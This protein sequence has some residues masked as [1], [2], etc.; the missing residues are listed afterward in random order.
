MA[1]FFEVVYAEIASLLDPIREASLSDSGLQSLLGQLG[2]DLE[3][4]QGL[5]L[6]PLLTALADVAA[7]VEAVQGATA[8]QVLSEV[9]AALHGVTSA[10][11]SARQLLASL[12]QA[13]DLPA[14][15]ADE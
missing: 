7:A 5:D 1:D 10:I 11:N 8:P 14:G 12:Q 9:A 13:P 15:L 6:G 2:L 3:V 4:V